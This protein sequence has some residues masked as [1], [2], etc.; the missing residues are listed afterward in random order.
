VRIYRNE[1]RLGYRANF[2]RV[3]ELCRS[4]LIAF[5]DQDDQWYSRKIGACVSEF[6]D[7]E[8]LLVYHNADVITADGVRLGG[9]DVFAAR[10]PLMPPL[11]LW[12]MSF[13]YGFTQVFRRDLLQLSSLWSMS[14]DHQDNSKPMA[15][16]QWIFFLASVLGN[17]GYVDQPLVAYVQHGRNT[18]G[19]SENSPPLHKPGRTPTNLEEECARHAQ[20]ARRRAEILETAIA[21]LNTLWSQRA[22]IA[23]KK[24]RWMAD[25][26]SYRSTIYGSPNFGTRLEAFC[27]ILTSAGYF[28]VW[29]LGR[30]PFVI[31]MCLGVPF[32]HL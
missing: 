24:Y 2:M 14:L 28:R 31:D 21:D 10:R 1:T 22:K 15:H 5:S 23:A 29:S 3:A 18:F 16:D 13:A 12:P 27:K 26:Y 32:G 30:K 6:K 4:D 8:T 9:L 20:A 25:M 11:S 7:P 17:V 19:W